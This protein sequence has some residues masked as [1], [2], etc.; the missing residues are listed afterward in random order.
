MAQ[1][2]VKE[3]PFRKTDLGYYDDDES[4]QSALEAY[5]EKKGKK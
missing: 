2:E 4:Y 5:Q 3:K 1:K